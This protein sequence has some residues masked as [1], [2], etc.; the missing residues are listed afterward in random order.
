MTSNK[1][2]QMSK[3]KKLSIKKNLK[4]LYLLSASHFVY[5]YVLNFTC[6]TPSILH[7]AV[8]SWGLAV[9]KAR[10]EILIHADTHSSSASFTCGWLRTGHGLSLAD[11][12]GEFFSGSLKVY[13]FIFQK[14]KKSSL[15]LWRLLSWEMLSRSVVAIL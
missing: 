1:S 4:C 11:C 12:E 3:S 15:L 2:K 10:E 6:L 9:P 7:G 14:L 8:V 13:F 5:K